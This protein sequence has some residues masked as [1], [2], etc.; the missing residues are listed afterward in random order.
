MPGGEG[1]EGREEP[2]SLAWGCMVGTC[3]SLCSGVFSDGNFTYIVEPREMARSLEPPQVSPSRSPPSY[4]LAH[5]HGL[6]QWL[7]RLLP[8]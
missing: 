1:V 4:A 3:A 8:W 6:S 2:L 5:P 7:S